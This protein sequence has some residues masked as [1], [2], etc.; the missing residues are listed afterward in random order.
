[1]QLCELDNLVRACVCF[2]VFC[3]EHQLMLHYIQYLSLYS[4]LSYICYCVIWILLQ[5]IIIYFIGKVPF[6]QPKLAPTPTTLTFLSE[7]STSSRCYS[8]AYKGSN[9]LYLGCNDGIRVLNRE[10]T[11]IISSIILRVTSVQ[12][13]NNSIY[14][15]D[16]NGDERT[17]Y[18]CLS[19]MSQ[20]E[21]LFSFNYLGNTASFIAVSKDYIVASEP[22][23]DELVLYNFSTRSTTLLTPAMPLFDMHFLPDGQL[24][25]VS[26]KQDALIR[27]KIENDQLITIW[28]CGGLEAASRVTS[29]VD[30]FI[31]VSTYKRKVI[32]IISPQG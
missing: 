13:C 20:R 5:H 12:V 24:L 28:T 4:K 7:H 8:A 19:D 21:K 16:S 31:Y 10:S 22:V 29:D 9:E 30:G 3:S 6:Q 25:V 17:V 26:V 23:K 18:Q 1:M 2:G 32:Y 15:L 11:E 14:V 27:Y